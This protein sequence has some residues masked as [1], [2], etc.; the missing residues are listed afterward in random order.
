MSGG[1]FC[2]GYGGGQLN[3]ALGT[4]REE[5]TASFRR[6]ATVPPRTRRTSRSGWSQ[7]NWAQLIEQCSQ[8]LAL[9]V[10]RALS[11]LAILQPEFN[12]FVRG[13]QRVSRNV[14][15][16]RDVASLDSQS[17]IAATYHVH[18]ADRPVWFENADA[19]M[20]A[21]GLPIRHGPRQSYSCAGYAALLAGAALSTITGVSNQVISGAAPKAFA[22]YSRHSVL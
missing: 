20:S 10:L 5:Q 8:G 2:S 6:F 18:T 21:A 19:P 1:Q 12:D 4:E 15:H 3:Q 22:T 11:H 16:A 17:F 14:D 7:P 13:L 9:G